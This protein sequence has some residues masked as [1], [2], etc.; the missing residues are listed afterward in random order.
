MDKIVSTRLDDMKHTM[1]KQY[2]DQFNFKNDSAALRD[3]IDTFFSEENRDNIFANR[4]NLDIINS[5]NINIEKLLLD[6][7][8]NKKIVMSLLYLIHQIDELILERTDDDN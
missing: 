1:L 7:K 4:Q 8:D 2:K 3:I 6:H 5:I